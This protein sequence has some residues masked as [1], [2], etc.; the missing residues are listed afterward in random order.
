MPIQ[1]VQL[2]KNGITHNFL[3]DLKKRFEKTND[4]KVVVLRNACR[5]KKQLQE[6]KEAIMTFLGKNFTERTVGYTI[7][8]KKWRMGGLKKRISIGE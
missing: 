1:T 5:D 3:E 2:G 8:I 4:I 7:S 6:K